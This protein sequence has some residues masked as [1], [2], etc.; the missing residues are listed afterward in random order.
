VRNQSRCCH[1]RAEKLRH[2]IPKAKL[3]KW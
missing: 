1:D 3:Q 2:R